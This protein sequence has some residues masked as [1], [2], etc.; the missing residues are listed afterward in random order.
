ML[1]H[2]TFIWQGQEYMLENVH[3]HTHLLTEVVRD[4]NIDDAWV[5]LCSL[6]RIGER[7]S[8]VLMMP[9]KVFL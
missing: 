9:G 1:Y 3:M 7:M 4:D 5:F 8:E 6:H 2:A